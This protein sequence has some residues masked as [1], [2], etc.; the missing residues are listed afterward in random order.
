[1]RS[2][3]ESCVR[4]RRRRGQSQRPPDRGRGW[5]SGLCSTEAA[6]ARSVRRLITLRGML[7]LLFVLGL[8]VGIALGVI[9]VAGVVILAAAGVAWLNGWAIVLGVTIRQ[10]WEATA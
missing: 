1:M 4:G 10:R 8:V 9:V 6:L 5:G 2:A 7:S 3:G